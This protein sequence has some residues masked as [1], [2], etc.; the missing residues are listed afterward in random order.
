LTKSVS[1]TASERVIEQIKQQM[2]KEKKLE[3]LRQQQLETANDV[4]KAAAGS[5]G[6]QTVKTQAKVSRIEKTERKMADKN[7]ETTMDPLSIDTTYVYEFVTQEPVTEIVY[8]E[9]TKS[10]TT[11]TTTTPPPPPKPTPTSPLEKARAI[12]GQSRRPRRQR[13]PPKS[14][15]QN[16]IEQVSH[17]LAASKDLSRVHTAG[18]LSNSIPHSNVGERLSVSSSNIQNHEISSGMTG[19]TGIHGDS[20]LFSEVQDTHYQ[21]GGKI[22]CLIANLYCYCESFSCVLSLY[23]H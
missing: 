4:S 7:Y 13:K 11:T 17:R 16:L 1:P 15:K 12:F 10:T 9:T 18:Q 20:Q 3:D 6:T 2:I 8:P 22:G 23:W 5:R 21:S 19:S 14:R